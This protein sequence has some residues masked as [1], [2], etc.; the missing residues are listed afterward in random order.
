M[1]KPS[2]WMAPSGWRPDEPRRLTAI[3]VAPRR[4]GVADPQPAQGWGFRVTNPPARLDDFVGI[5]ID[6]FL[7]E[8]GSLCD[9]DL[10]L[11]LAPSQ[12]AGRSSI[13]GQPLSIFPH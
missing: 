4:H 11:L 5:T 12:Q 6:Q 9:T 2:G 1:V 8:G 10:A 3:V 7:L 13:R